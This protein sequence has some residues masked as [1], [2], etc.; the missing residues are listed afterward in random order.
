MVINSATLSPLKQLFNA[1][2][3][4]LPEEKAQPSGFRLMARK[5]NS[6]RIGD[7]F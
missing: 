4:A 1:P 7:F 3:A 6:V 5:K 2:K